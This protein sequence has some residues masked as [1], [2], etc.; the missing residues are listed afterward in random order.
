MDGLS[1][2]KGAGI[3]QFDDETD[4]Y[5]NGEGRVEEVRSP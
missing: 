2:D 1:E 4:R 5:V 3:G